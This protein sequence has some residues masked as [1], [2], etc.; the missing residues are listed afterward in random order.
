MLT[1]ED[2]KQ[3]LQVGL[4]CREPNLSFDLRRTA[5]SET[6]WCSA[7]LSP[8]KSTMTSLFTIP[9]MKG[10]AAWKEWIF[11]SVLLPRQVSS[12]LKRTRSTT[13]LQSVLMC[14]IL[15]WLSSSSVDQV[16]EDWGF[17]DITCLGILHVSLVTQH[18]PVKSGTHQHSHDYYSGQCV[19]FTPVY[20]VLPFTPVWKG[21]GWFNRKWLSSFVWHYNAPL[22]S[23]IRERPKS[24]PRSGSKR[25]VS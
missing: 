23:T 5:S 17:V 22:I 3:I 24:A 20:F 12:I 25:A 21:C 1:W 9:V 2:T 8:D 10:R 4:L 18:R 16:S 19:S 13:N 11:N 6:L 7:L 14:F 15:R